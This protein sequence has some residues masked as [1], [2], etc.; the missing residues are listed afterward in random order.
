M[1]VITEVAQKLITAKYVRKKFMIERMCSIAHNGC[2]FEQDAGG[3]S[4][5][6]LRRHLVQIR[7]SAKRSE[8]EQRM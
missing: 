7:C 3:T 2:G 4:A 5:A 1:G 6:K 8:A